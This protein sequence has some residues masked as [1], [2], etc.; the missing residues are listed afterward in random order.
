MVVSVDPHDD[1]LGYRPGM[2]VLREPNTAASAVLIGL[3]M[4]AGSTIYKRNSSV[5]TDPCALEQKWYRGDVHYWDFVELRNDMTGQ[6]E[7]GGLARGDLAE[8]IDFRWRRTGSTLTTIYN[9]TEHTIEFTLSRRSDGVCFLAFP[10]HPFVS[11]RPFTL[12]LS[13]IPVFTDPA[14]R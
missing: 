7:D 8:R 11:D 2:W 5:T 12:T 13:N 10:V 6:W 9:S 4:L 14:R 3:C 1:G